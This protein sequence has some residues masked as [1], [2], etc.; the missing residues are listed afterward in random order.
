MTIHF[1]LRKKIIGLLQN[2][3]RLSEQ[4]MADRLQSDPATVATI[5]SDLEKEK[6][7]IGY[8]ALINDELSGNGEVKALI[9]VQVLPERDG[10]FDR[11]A[12]TICRFS[13]VSSVYLVSGQYDL[14]V[15][16]AGD[17]LQEVALFVSSRLAPIE[18][19]QSTA[20]HFLLKKYKDAGFT[21]E[22]DEH[23]ERLKIS[24]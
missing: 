5:L 15:E 17:S 3:A 8:H 7:I 1:E 20:T 21:V 11:V 16:V 13:E 9:E 18:G 4:E 14:R 12:R 6:V 19:V 10:G 22:K 23:Y 24:P 2:N